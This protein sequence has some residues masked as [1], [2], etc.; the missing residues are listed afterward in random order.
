M[1]KK[2]LITGAILAISS[3]VA[4]ADCPYAGFGVNMRDNIKNLNSYRGIEGSVFVGYGGMVNP[5]FQLAGELFGVPGSMSIN[6]NGLKTSYGY[7][8][9]LIPSMMIT[10]HA[11]TFVRFGIVRTYFTGASRQVTGGQLGLGLQTGLTQN[12]DIRA[13]YIYT[14]YNSVSSALGA[15]KSDQAQLSLVYKFE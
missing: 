11:M 9:S 2:L 13:E 8:A 10:E 3:S 4:F 5:I 12:W 6:N 7:G 15:P 14:A 1:F